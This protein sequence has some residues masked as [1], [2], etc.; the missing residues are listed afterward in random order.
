MTI[1]QIIIENSI[2]ANK[3]WAGFCT[4]SNPQI[5]NDCNYLLGYKYKIFS[6]I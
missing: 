5:L 4:S 1:A 3:K 6:S 2:W